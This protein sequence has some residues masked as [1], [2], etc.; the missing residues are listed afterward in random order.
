MHMVPLLVI[1]FAL[2]YYGTLLEVY[3][4]LGEGP[5]IRPYRQDCH[6]Y[7][8]HLHHEERLASCRQSM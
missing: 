8:Y 7:G 1:T 3:F 4:E 6:L 2:T 5:D